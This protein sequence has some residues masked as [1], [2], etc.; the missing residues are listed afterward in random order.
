[1]SFDEPFD[2][3]RIFGEQETQPHDA[4]YRA[5]KLSSLEQDDAALD[6]PVP[7]PAFPSFDGQVDVARAEDFF[8]PDVQAQFPSISEIISATVN[9]AAVQP[10]LMN[11]FSPAENTSKKKKSQN[12]NKRPAIKTESCNDDGS[13]TATSPQ[14]NRTLQ[15]TAAQMTG[16]SFGLDQVMDSDPFVSAESQPGQ[17]DPGLN[18]LDAGI[19]SAAQTPCEMANA[20]EHQPERISVRPQP[21]SNNVEPTMQQADPNIG[22]YSIFMSQPSQLPVRTDH[23]SQP[24][25]TSGTENKRKAVSVRGMET[26]IKRRQ[27]VNQDGAIIPIS[28]PSP[29]F[30]DISGSQ[31]QV[32]DHQTSGQNFNIPVRSYHTPQQQIPIDPALHFGVSPPS[33]YSTFGTAI[34]AGVCAVIKTILKE[35]KSRGTVLSQVL[36]DGPAADFSSPETSARIKKATKGHLDEVNAAR[37]ETDQQAFNSGTY[38]AFHGIVEE[39]AHH[40]AVFGKELVAGPVSGAEL[41]A[42]KRAMANEYKEVIASYMSPPRFGSDFARLAQV[43]QTPTRASHRRMTA[44]EAFTLAGSPELPGH[45][46]FSGS[47]GYDDAGFPQQ[48]DYPSSPFGK[49]ASPALQSYNGSPASV[50][51]SNND[52]LPPPPIHATTPS[53]QQPQGLDKA[54][55]KKTPKKPATPR[56]S[57]S[58]RSSTATSSPLN[59]NPASTPPSTTG[60][61]I[62]KLYHSFADGAWYMLLQ[63]DNNTTNT[64]NTNGSNSSSSSSSQGGGEAAGA[65]AT[66]HRIGRGTAATEAALAQFLAEARVKLGVE[67]GPAGFVYRQWLG[68]EGNLAALREFVGGGSGSGDGVGGGGEVGVI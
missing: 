33:S 9:N 63:A 42:V 15:Q 18:M 52:M 67:E 17:F 31:C 32:S 61:C 59:P 47:P 13:Q 23:W 1:M 46:F 7:F 8:S 5:A 11:D 62:P 24:A 55:P 19:L 41:Q 26:P 66:H 53:R 4:A 29:L 28:Q 64:T 21:Y 14:S 12:R 20:A 36:M 30:T 57:R 58:R 54:K 38:K 2:F 50:P 45:A 34:K 56:K 10:E 16:F 39:I 65:G 48:S 49:L 51:A 40:G 25:A 27:S 60:Q 3:E 43:Q 22:E 37:P 68:V 6:Q 35:A 44:P